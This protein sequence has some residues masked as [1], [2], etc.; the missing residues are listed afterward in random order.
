MKEKKDIVDFLRERYSLN[1]QIQS[2]KSKRSTEG[3][4]GTET[5]IL[6]EMQFYL[7]KLQARI[8]KYSAASTQWDVPSS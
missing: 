1:E 2:L 3:L 6:E 5:V 7:E 4:L 8:E